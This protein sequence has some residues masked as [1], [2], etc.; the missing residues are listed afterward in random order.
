MLDV[1][2]FRLEGGTLIVT[3]GA[4]GLDSRAQPNPAGPSETPT[5]SAPRESTPAAPADSTMPATASPTEAPRDAL[6][7]VP[8]RATL[9]T[10]TGEAIARATATVDA[11]AFEV[12]LGHCPKCISKRSGDA[13]ACPSCGLVFAQADALSFNPSDWLKQQWLELLQGWGDDAR[14]EALRVEAMNKGELAEMG[15]LYRL[16]LADLPE[17]PYALRGRDEVLR[18]AVLP[19]LTVRQV[20]TVPPP[21]AMWKYLA[22]GAVIIGCI[23]ALIIMIRQILT[24]S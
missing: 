13:F 6:G 19:Q 11:R 14:H 24:G 4:C 12:P 1:G 21:P 10:P 7:E 3:C 16:R 15:R 2:R 17:D 18:L 23:A 9:R 5:S 22:S 8:A 20:S